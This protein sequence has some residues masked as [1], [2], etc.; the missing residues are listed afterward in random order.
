MIAVV[1][2]VLLAWSAFAVAIACASA[3]L[4]P[5]LRARLLA[6]G[7]ASRARAISYVAAAPFAAAATLMAACFLPSLATRLA[8]G[9]DHC[10]HHDDVH[11]HFC[12]MHASG[13][14]SSAGLA[15]LLGVL[16]ALGALLVLEVLRL[17]RAHR[18][19]QRLARLAEGSL[20]MALTVGLF[21]PRVIIGSTL[22][23]ILP[24]QLLA[25]VVAHERAHVERRDNLRKVVTRLFA[26]LHAPR[27]RALLQEDLE[28]A[29]E[30]ACDRRAASE[31]GDPLLV[32]DAI[33]A[34]ERLCAPHDGMP[35]LASAFGEGQ[36]VARVEA[37]LRHDAGPTEDEQPLSRWFLPLGCIVLVAAIPLHDAIEDLVSLLGH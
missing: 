29:C 25:V 3:L 37:L 34:A 36:V 17:G 35:V 4:Y 2:L 19:A 23:G 33:L 21:R 24:A 12:W 32:A 18:R 30:E 22:A 6:L 10:T 11:A 9:S 20:P 27:V 5:A 15:L 31:A 13:S 26:L 7:P 16:G 1:Q 8:T 14:A 28:L